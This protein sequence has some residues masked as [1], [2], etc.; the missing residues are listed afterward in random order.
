MWQEE[1]YH[2]FCDV[3]GIVSEKYHVVQLNEFDW[4]LYVEMTDKTN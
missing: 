4:C 2:Y 3:E 1:K